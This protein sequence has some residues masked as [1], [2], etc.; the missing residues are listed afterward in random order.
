MEGEIKRVRMGE[1]R[2]EV[3]EGGREGRKGE[4]GRET[5]LL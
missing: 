2:R 3:V 1:P 5:Y 4:G